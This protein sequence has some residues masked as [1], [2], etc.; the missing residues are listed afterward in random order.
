MTTEIARP[1]VPSRGGTGSENFPDAELK[2]AFTGLRGARGMTVTDLP[3][4][5]LVYLILDDLGAEDEA[6]SRFTAA[7]RRW[8]AAP[9]ELRCVSTE[10]SELLTISQAAR[11]YPLD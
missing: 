9:I 4:G 7:K 5:T 11:L 1:Q 2:Q 10:E 6:F 3:S 8:G